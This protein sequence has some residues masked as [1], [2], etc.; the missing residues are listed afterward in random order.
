VCVIVDTSSSHLIFNDPNTP[1]AAPVWRWLSRG[2]LLVYGGRLATELL[3]TA[4]GRR[5]LRQLSAAGWAQEIPTGDITAAEATLK[6]CA[7]LRSNDAHV[8]GLAVASGA[9][10]LITNDDNLVT[11]FT[12]PAILRPKGRIYSHP[13]HYRLL[14]HVRGC[15]GYRS[16]RRTKKLKRNF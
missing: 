5:I 15:R 7:R 9:R 12:D 3:V 1:L 4:S 2:G 6:A 10:T 13:S 8:L 14:Q 16:G 11:D